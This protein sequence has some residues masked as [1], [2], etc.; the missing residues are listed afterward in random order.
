MGSTGR[1]IRITGTVQGVGFRPWVYRLAR[2]AGVG[3][4]VRN[5]ATGV[6]IEAFGSVEEIERLLAALGGDP[7]PAA[8]IA[9]LEVEE[10]T[11]PKV[12]ESAVPGIEDPAD[13]EAEETAVGGWEDPAARA[14][15]FTIVG[16]ESSEELKVSIPPDLALCADCAREVDA[17]GD[18]R[19]RYPFTNCTNCGPRFTITLDLP[20]DRPATTMA[21]FVM[22]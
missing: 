11:V 20:Y 17:P 14:G 4:T 2:A 8:S 18:R 19:H 22:C 1:R 21:S 5:D 16:S 12:E 13:S 7:P 3:G 10:I 15:E 9:T 6:T